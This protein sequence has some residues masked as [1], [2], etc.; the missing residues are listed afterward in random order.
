M[1]ALILAAGYG[2]RL[3]PLTI[4]QPKPLLKV[5]SKSILGHI[6]EKLDVREEIDE[7][8]VV[9]NNKFYTHFNKW[10]QTFSSNKT[11]TIINDKT[12]NNQDRLGAIGD[13]N[14]VIKDQNI[15]EDLLII[16]GDNLFEDN[17]S[18]IFNLFQEKGNTIMLNDVKNIELAK[19]YGIVSI[20]SEDK[21]TNFVEKPESP[22]STLASTL[23]YAI[24]KE[25]LELINHVLKQGLA[26]RAGDFIKYLSENRTVSGIPL[27]GK[28]FDIG[29]LQQLK[30]AEATYSNQVT[31]TVKYN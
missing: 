31:N 14:Y 11:I 6:V 23:I 19:L 2:T 20:N 24:K 7:I 15:E 3:Y 18:A 5:G 13:I 8:F 27:T 30:E 10:K 12:L 17:L 22:E 9:T 25:D 29:S 1:K 28:W 4:N 21:I 26:D 16:G